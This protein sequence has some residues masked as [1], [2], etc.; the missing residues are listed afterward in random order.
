MSEILIKVGKSPEIRDTG[1]KVSTILSYFSSGDTIGS[2]IHA[3]SGLINEEDIQACLE[4][5]SKLIKSV[6]DS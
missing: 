4:F 1:V 2:I 3:Y 5:A 6:Y